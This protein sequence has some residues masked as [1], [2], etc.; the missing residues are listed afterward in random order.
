MGGFFERKC[1]SHQSGQ[2]PFLFFFKS[3]SV[4]RKKKSWN[5]PRNTGRGRS[6]FSTSRYYVCK[7]PSWGISWTLYY[8]YKKS[9]LWNNKLA[10]CKIQNFKLKSKMIIMYR[11]HQL[12]LTQVMPEYL[13]DFEKIILKHHKQKLS[14]VVPYIFAF[15]MFT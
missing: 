6:S 2:N 1:F 7:F 4:L 12:K 11:K 8:I 13:L 9:Q 15:S 3:F 10:T 14:E 5:W